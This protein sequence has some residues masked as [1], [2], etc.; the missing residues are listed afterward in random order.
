ME[1]KRSVL[2]EVNRVKT[3]LDVR[4]AL[5]AEDADPTVVPARVA[6]NDPCS[7]GHRAEIQIRT[8]VGKNEAGR[9]VLEDDVVTVFQPVI[10]LV[11]HDAFSAGVGGRLQIGVRLCCC[12]WQGGDGGR[13]GG[14]DE[15]MR[16]FMLIP[17]N[18]SI[19][20]AP[21][22]CAVICQH[23]VASND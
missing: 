4:L 12:D 6:G 16:W 9:P 13:Y 11:V 22:Q 8:D 7:H 17:S 1:L 18:G 14:G 5:M 23:Y 20:Q 19:C 2:A 15:A 21:E 3:E 10:L